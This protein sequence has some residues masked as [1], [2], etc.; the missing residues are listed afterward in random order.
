MDR[1]VDQSHRIVRVGEGNP[2]GFLTIGLPDGDSDGIPGV[3][4]DGDELGL[5]AELAPEVN[6]VSTTTDDGVDGYS[7]SVRLFR[8]K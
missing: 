1:L 2:Q 5:F 4:V 6:G 3:S 8:Q 7:P